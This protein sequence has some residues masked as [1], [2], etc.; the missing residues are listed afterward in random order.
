MSALKPPVIPSSDDSLHALFL[1]LVLPRVALHGRIRFRHLKSGDQRED[2]IAEMIGLTWLWFVMLARRGKD[3]TRFVSA[4]ASF[5]ARR[6]NRGDRVCG[7]EWA[8]D[9]LNTLAQQRHGFKVQSL[10][11]RN[12]ASLENRYTHPRGQHQQ[13]VF[14]ERLR[15]NTTTPVPIQV[16][17]RLDLRA[18]MKTLTGRE[19]RLIRAM[20]R[21]ER[22]TDLSR[23]F[24]LSPGRISQLRR[25]FHQAWLRFCGDLHGTGQD[26]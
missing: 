17:V 16:Q 26:A 3:A 15:D 9:V 24:E 23:Q 12:A 2:A 7:Q 8:K 14:E 25:E 19:R 1:T 13:D 5:A 10:P 22:T 11:L 18:W 21:N 20:A 4:L 6:V